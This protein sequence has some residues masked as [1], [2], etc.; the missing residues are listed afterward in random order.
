MNIIKSFVAALSMYSRIPMP[1]FEWREENMRYSLLFFPV[2]G[3]IIGGV[4]ILWHWLVGIALF[5]VGFAAAIA[6]VIPVLVTGGIHMDG[7]CD[8]VDALSSYQSRER[9][10]EILKDP[11][12]GAFAVTGVIVYFILCYGGW[13]L[14]ESRTAVCMVALGYVGSRGMSGLAAVY[15]PAAKQTGSLHSFS[16]VA[17]RRVVRGGLIAVFF[18]TAALQIYLCPPVGSVLFLAELALYGYYYRMSLKKFG[19]ITGDLAGWF[20]QCMELLV[21]YVCGVGMFLTEG[22]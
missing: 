16:S 18:L 7:Y 5:P 3:V 22:L 14:L 19:G 4:Q 8:T 17:D 9:R 20:L 1:Q 13:Y 21:L 15:F 11:H 10:L 2:V 12:T 6:V